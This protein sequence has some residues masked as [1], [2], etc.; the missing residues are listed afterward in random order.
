MEAGQTGLA[1]IIK[2][3]RFTPEN[4]TGRAFAGFARSLTL[5]TAAAKN[6]KEAMIG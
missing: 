6:R 2:G 3:I 1:E 5:E 4:Q